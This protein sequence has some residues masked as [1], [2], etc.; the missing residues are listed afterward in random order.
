MSRLRA[1]H[2]EHA[3]G[4]G[5]GSRIVNRRRRELVEQAC[6]DR[7]DHDEYLYIY[8]VGVSRLRTH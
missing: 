6:D 5:H 7:H 1:Q 2:G 4:G 8:H 3:P